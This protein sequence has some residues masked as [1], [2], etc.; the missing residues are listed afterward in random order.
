M[1]Y[2]RG[3]TATIY[4]SFVTL[5]DKEPTTIVDPK[6]TI[7]HVDEL[8][9]VVTDIDEAA[10]TLAAENTYYYKWAISASAFLGEYNVECEATV[11]GE[12]AESNFTIQ[13]E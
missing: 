9:Q 5:E 1:A 2:N 4:C 6:V 11:D 3:E 8:N 10:M 13:V 7:R 12:Y